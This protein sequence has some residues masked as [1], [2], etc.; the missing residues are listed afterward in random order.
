M[1]VSV[2]AHRSRHATIVEVSEAWMR[3]HHAGAI[4]T[5]AQCIHAVHLSVAIHQ[6]QGRE[7]DVADRVRSWTNLIRSGA[8]NAI[9]VDIRDRILAHSAIAIPARHTLASASAWSRSSVGH[10]ELLLMAK[11][12]ISTC[13][14]SCTLRTLERLFFRVRS[15]MSLEMFQAGER[16]SARLAHVRPWLIRLGRWECGLYSAIGIGCGRGG[17]GGGAI[18]RFRDVRQSRTRGARAQSRRVTLRLLFRGIL[19]VHAPIFQ[20]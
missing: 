19:C 2:L 4:H 1:Q 11:Q 8:I 16:P 15:F 18:A 3:T 14:T 17:R 10:V 12:Q 5:Q 7:I 9:H 6:A 13:E 20:Q